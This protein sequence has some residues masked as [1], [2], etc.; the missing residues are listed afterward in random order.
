[1]TRP[2]SKAFIIPLLAAAATSG[3]ALGQTSELYLTSWDTPQ[4]FVVQ[5]GAIVRQFNRSSTSDGPGLV[6]QSSVKCIGQDAGAI[7]REYDLNG[8]PLS[9][10]YTN[11]SYSSL[12]DGA[13]DGVHNWSIAHNDFNTNFAVVQGD[14]DWQ[15]LQVLFV[16]VN[17]SSGITYDS[18]RNSLWI[19]NNI[20]GSDR[21]QQF[22]LNG[23]LLSEFPVSLQGGGGYGIAWDP[24]D[25][26]L[27]LTGAFGDAG[28]IY[29]YST[30]G[31]ALQTLAIPG[32]APNILGAEFQ[33]G[34]GQPRYTLRISG[35]CPGTLTVSWSNATP[36]RQ[37]GIVFGNNLGSTI[38]PG[39]PCAGTMLG[40]AGNVRL[41]NTVGT[42]NG[43]GSVNGQAGTS[44]CGHYLQLVESGS[45]NTSN[46]AQIP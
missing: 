25:D 22:D 20:G 37:Q 19:S 31:A 3:A 36:S 8:A 24:A 44:A 43:S 45:C 35:A 38:I 29:Q 14:A 18:S 6:V 21:V 16:P 17:R 5:N 46:V 39:G 15:N 1:M 2:I 41:V 7:G 34:G 28:R 42:G 40:I 9:G 11:P 26:T 13:T 33:A 32:I 10:T 27:W 23:N 12:Y 4:T 30:S